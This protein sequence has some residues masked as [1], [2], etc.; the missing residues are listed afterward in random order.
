MI[1]LES[2]LWREIAIPALLLFAL[3]LAGPLLTPSPAIA[4]QPL[5]ELLRGEVV[6]PSGLPVAGIT[7]SLHRVGDSGGAELGRALTD[8][9]GRFEIEVGDD[10]GSGVYFAAT[11]FEGVLYMGEVFRTLQEAPADYRIVIGVGGIDGGMAQPL[12]L[13][14]AESR[15]RGMILLLAALGVGAVLV[16]VLRARRGPYQLR[17]AL[18]EVAE[19]DEAHAALPETERVARGDSYRAARAELYERIRHLSGQ[20]IAHAADHD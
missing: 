2:R 11:R 8:R 14:G 20:T 9:E 7:V 10:D 12:P 4:G 1:Q 3:L 17:A 5:Q 13:D 19:L 16:P 6:D 18:A 15:G